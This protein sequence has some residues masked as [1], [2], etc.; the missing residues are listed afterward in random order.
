MAHS[1]FLRKLAFYSFVLTMV[2]LTGVANTTPNSVEVNARMSDLEPLFVQA[3]IGVKYPMT[4]FF[5]PDGAISTVQYATRQQSSFTDNQHPPATSSPPT[6]LSRK[7][8]LAQIEPT[9]D[10]P[11]REFDAMLFIIHEHVCTACG[12]ER[13][14]LQTYAEAYPD[15]HFAVVLVEFE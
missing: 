6:N 3:S 2:P 12:A 9:P 10:L 1:V 15:A 5:A 13:N 7:E 4:L 8:I 14:A 11:G